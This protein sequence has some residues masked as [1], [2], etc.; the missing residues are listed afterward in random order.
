M[1]D[2]TTIRGR[3]LCGAVE[4][5]LTP[6]TD[7]VAH[8]HCRSCR[9]AH[10]S[11]VTTWTSVPVDRFDFQAGEDLV[12]WYASSQWIEWGFCPRC[13]SSMLYRVV[14]EGHH[15]SPRMG[16]MYVAAGS[17][18][19]PLDREPRAHV[20]YEERVDWMRFDDHLPKFRGKTTERM[21]EG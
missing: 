8:C 14:E 21:D 6:P 10:G 4:F 11:A 15:E 5:S 16:T 2:H 3:C 9:L 13:G 19:D 7:F 1:D 18:V 12:R 17:L 20:S